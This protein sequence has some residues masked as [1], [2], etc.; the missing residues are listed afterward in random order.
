[1]MATLKHWAAGGGTQNGGGGTDANTAPNLGV[2]SQIHFP[3]F[4]AGIKAGAAAVMTGYQSVSGVAMAVNKQMVT[5]TLKTAWGFDGFVISDWNT[6]SGR[7]A[8]CINA[9][10]DLCMT[11]DPTQFPGVVKPLVPGTIPQSRI[12]DAVKR[13]LRVKFRMGLFENPWPNLNLNN[14]IGSQEYRNVARACVRK[15]LVLL[16]NDNNGAKVLPLSKTAHIFVAGAWADNIGYQCGGWSATNSTLAANS[17]VLTS[18]DEGW[19]GSN[20]AHKIPGATTILQ[21]LQAVNPNVTYNAAGTGMPA[22]TDVIVVAVGET[23]YAEYNGDRTDI[24][25]PADQQTL[26]Q[27]CANTGKPVVTI[28]ITG[29]PNVLGSIATNSKAIVAAWLPGT[30]GEGIADILYGDFN[31]TGKLSVTWPAS[32]GQEPINTGTMGDVSGSGGAPL[33]AYGFGLTYP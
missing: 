31:F 28:L 18:G 30:E 32:N 1:M 13:L 16:K 8:A 2:L 19:Q 25:L 20:A 27:T 10:H 12:D 9:G 23:P 29:R 6:S 14:Y 24:S 21:A 33:Y 15:S 4:V 17:N 5:D 26:V 3:P 11:V 7:E 22:N